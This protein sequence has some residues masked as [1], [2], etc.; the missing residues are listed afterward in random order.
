MRVSVEVGEEGDE[1]VSVEMGEEVDESE[2]GG[3][4]VVVPVPK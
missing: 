3:G 2:C 1:S 4:A